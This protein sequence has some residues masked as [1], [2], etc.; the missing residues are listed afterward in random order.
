M[1]HELDRLLRAFAARPWAI[2][3]ERGLEIAEALALRHAAGP[4]SEPFRADGPAPRGQAQR[5]ASVA[6]IP[7][8]GPLAPRVTSMQDVS[9]GFTSVSDFMGLFREA[10]ASDRVDRIV[11]DV[12]SP[13]G[14][15]DLIPEAA[16]MV[17]A[18]RKPVTAV[19]N[20]TAASAAYWIASQAGRFY[21]SPS[22][23]VGSIGVRAMHQDLSGAL[24][25]R[26]IA[27][28]HIHAGPRKVEGNPYQPLD[29]AARAALQA[30]VDEA[31]AAFV[32]DVAAARGVAETVVRADPEMASAHF[33]GGRAY[34]A[35]TAARLGMVDGMM[36][37]DAAIA[38]ARGGGRSVR[39]E[40]ERLALI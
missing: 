23:T 8:H 13:G 16:A 7:L 31:Y 39:A 24:K 9:A 29:K 3:P 5:T 26:G 36:T 33:G 37:L 1:A 35:A 18:S 40:R 15:V 19:A 17:R 12:D 10:E 30:E 28:T 20:T 4:R 38:E 27:V 34:G 6:V 32:A 25:Q 14:M 11:L 22:A 2:E 21:A